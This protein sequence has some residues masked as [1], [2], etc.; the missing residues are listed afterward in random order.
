MSLKKGDQVQGNELKDTDSEVPHS[1]SP[2]PPPSSPPASL[3]AF[4]PRRSCWRCLRG[5]PLYVSAFTSSVLRAG[6]VGIPV[7][8]DGVVEAN[9][10]EPGGIAR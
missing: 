4:V 6:A 7:V 8:G 1:P 5:R 2:P 9:A 3:G 10:F